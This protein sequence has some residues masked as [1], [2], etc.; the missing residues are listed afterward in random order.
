V[1]LPPRQSGEGLAARPHLQPP[2]PR[3]PSQPPT[4]PPSR[5]SRRAVYSEAQVGGERGAGGG[6]GG[7]GGGCVVERAS[8]AG[9]GLM[10]GE[11]GNGQRFWSVEVSSGTPHAG[12]PRARRRWR[13]ACGG[14]L[15]ATA[16]CGRVGGLGNGTMEGNF[17]VG[18][19]SVKQ[20][21]GQTKDLL[22]RVSV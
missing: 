15:S 13:R 20:A 4:V 22:A 16:A 3:T 21:V 5:A 10:A 18:A 11:P 12:P 2:P 7:G 17:A 14:G 9:A 8:E 6:I 19:G 1:H